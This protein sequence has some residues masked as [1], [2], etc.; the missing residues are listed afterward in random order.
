MESEKIIVEGRI[1]TGF[2]KKIYRTAGILFVCGIIGRILNIG[3]CRVHNGT[4]S[5]RS[6][7]DNILWYPIGLVPFLL[8]LAILLLLFSFIL[9]LLSKTSITVTNTRV[10]GKVFLNKRVDLPLDMISAVSTCALKGIGVATSSGHI[11]FRLIE[12]NLEIH[13]AITKLL[14][15]RQ[16]QSSKSSVQ[17][18]PQNTNNIDQLKSLKELLDSGVISQEE[19][20]AKKKQILGL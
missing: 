18:Q 15:E 2:T 9:F 3:E 16:G 6:I 12:N 1:A 14:S 19:F 8:D 10:Y 4:G 20:D 17:V 7:I 11:H 5:H 13:E